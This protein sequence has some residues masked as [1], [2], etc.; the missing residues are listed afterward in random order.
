MTSRNLSTQLRALV[1]DDNMINR[2]IHQKMLNGL[3]VECMG[4][5]NGK[6]AVDVHCYG[7]SFDLILMDK[8]MPIMNGI[9]AT[10]KLRSMGICSMIVGVS[11]R[12]MEVEIREFMEAGLNDYHEKPLTT[13]KLASIIHHIINT[14]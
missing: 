14:K 6:E 11:S 2:K 9:E 8:D 1:V 7:Q 3:G 4:V 10:K 5:A 12:S 13:A